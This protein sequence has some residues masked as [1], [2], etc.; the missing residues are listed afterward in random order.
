M[1]SLG[2]THV[3]ACGRMSVSAHSS[4][5][6][7]S[8]CLLLSNRF[9]GPQLGN[10]QRHSV[11]FDSQRRRISLP[12][13]IARSDSKGAE[14]N[15]VVLQGAIIPGVN[16]PTSNDAEELNHIRQGGDQSHLVRKQAQKKMLKQPPIATQLA[17]LDLSTTNYVDT[18]V[19]GCGPAGLMLASEL[20]KRGVSVALIGVESAFVN[21]YGVW[22]DEFQAL[23]LADTLDQRWSHCVCYLGSDEPLKLMRAYGRVGRDRL[24]AELLK[25]CKEAGVKYLNATVADCCQDDER[26]SRIKLE[27]GG[28]ITCRLAIMCSGAASGKF[29][30]YEKEGPLVG[31]QTAYGI[32]AE[33][34]GFTKTCQKD[35]MYFMDYREFDDVEEEG[36]YKDIPSFLYMMPFDDTHAF[37]EE[38]CLVSRPTVPFEVLKK[39]LHKRMAKMGM[40]VVHL[41]EEEWSY[42]P[43]GGPLPLTQQPVVGFGAAANMVH[44]A[45]GA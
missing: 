36:P 35:R 29:L 3:E 6:P 14:R 39:R 12:L 9:C 25:R 11:S 43:V 26:R 7:F 42:I 19:V 45:T 40:E 16:M 41:E 23:G 33:I 32:E 1:T 31:V 4:M 15:H 8:R 44:P 27:S 5:S 30:H 37:L 2:V 34:S 17:P 24:R 38:T 18:V 21:N 28:S 10:A 22:I 20:G 13:T